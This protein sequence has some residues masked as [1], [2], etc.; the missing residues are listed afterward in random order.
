MTDST[1]IEEI[2]TAEDTTRIRVAILSDTHGY[3]DPRVAEATTGADY[4][5]HAGDIMG[6]G[7]LEE[8]KACAGR[9]V[10][11]AGNNDR[12][13]IWPDGADEVVRDLPR[14]ARLHLPGGTLAVEHGERHGHNQ[15]DHTALR[16]AHS[17]ARLIVYGHTHRLCQDD[18]ADPRI[19][20]PGAAGRTR[21][22]GGPS[23]LILEAE[24]GAWHLETLRFPR[25]AALA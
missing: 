10:A 5:V 4:A 23:C 2:H 9:V 11:V 16:R 17:A 18:E 8:L 22:H 3:L 13:G 7:I 12:P 20:N 1:L 19:V 25:E 21:T 14:T 15:P 24:A 6:A